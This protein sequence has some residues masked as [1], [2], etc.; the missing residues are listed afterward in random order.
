[1]P[2]HTQCP[3]CGQRL[4][5]EDRL[6]GRTVRCPKCQHEVRFPEPALEDAA[7][8]LL[9][10][11][12]QEPEAPPSPALARRP[13]PPPVAATPMFAT[14]EPPAWLRHLHW[15]LVLALVPLA[16]TMLKKGETEGDLLRRLDESIEKAPPEARAKAVRAME[17]ANADLDDVITALPRQRLLG[18]ALPRNTHWHWAFAL[19][20]IVL[21]MSFFVFLGTGGVAKPGHLLAVGLFTG[22]VGIL[23]L[24][25]VQVI[26]MVSDGIKPGGGC[27]VM[28]F[29]AFAKLIGASYRAALDPDTGFLLSFLGFTAGVGFLEELCKAVPVL[30]YFRKTRREGWR[31]GF[32][33]GLASGAGFGISE[34]VMYSADFYNG[35]TG[36]GIYVVRFVSCV[37]LHA[38]WTGTVAITVQ[39]K[40]EWLLK[41]KRVRD[42][43]APVFVY[44]AVPVVLHGLYDTLLKKDMEG[45]ALLVALLSFGFLAYLVSRRH[46]ADDEK[47]TAAMLK[48]YKKWRK[49]QG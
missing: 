10:R 12:E 24:V 34:G 46:G 11:L 6:A 22:T 5:G 17:D 32:L 43:I 26:A 29:L 23:F 42:C 35:I 44:I 9:M 40:Q 21:Y 41:A 36:S 4:R 37:A 3:G 15:L 30:F 47:E 7:A 45:L 31:G 19:G 8:A 20:A 48:Q 49:S 39:Q 33:W 27:V 1:M 16:V 25:I 18:A 13:E 38:L 28:V 2:L 14:K